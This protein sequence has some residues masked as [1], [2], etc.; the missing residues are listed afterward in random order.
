MPTFE[1]YSAGSF[2]YKIDLV[3]RLIAQRLSQN[4]KAHNFDVTIEQWRILLYLWKQ[5]GQSQN[6]LALSTQKD[7]PSVSRILNNM[8][9]HDLVVRKRHPSD[10][11]TNLIYLTE[12]GRNLQDDLMAIGSLTNKEATEGISSEELKQCIETLNKVINNLLRVRENS[13]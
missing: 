4:F 12:K 6:S 7:E 8:E 2:G 5:D 11:R 9:K 1:T 3:A 10:R 13:A